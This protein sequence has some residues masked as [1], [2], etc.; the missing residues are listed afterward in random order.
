[1]LNAVKI[2]SGIY[3]SSLIL[4]GCTREQ[5][6][7]NGQ[8]GYLRYLGTAVGDQGAGLLSL[9]NG[10]VGVLFSSV[11]VSGT[12]NVFWSQLN[13]AGLAGGPSVNVSGEIKSLAVSLIEA[14]DGNMVY[15]GIVVDGTSSGL[16]VTKFRTAGDIVWQKVFRNEGQPVPV[17]LSGTEEGDIFVFGHTSGTDNSDAILLK[18]NNSGSLIWTRQIVEGDKT[19]E[20]LAMVYSNGF[21]YL[22]VRSQSFVIEGNSNTL[23]LR[24]SADGGILDRALN[25]YNGTNNAYNYIT[26]MEGE[27]A[28]LLAGNEQSVNGTTPCAL[29]V[30]LTDFGVLA[31]YSDSLRLG[32]YCGAISLDDGVFLIGNSP[33][34]NLNGA[35]ISQY[36]QGGDFLVHRTFAGS[37]AASYLTTDNQGKLVVLCTHRTAVSSDISILAITR[38]LLP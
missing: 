21:L 8:H 33:D 32:A 7:D 15:C 10:Q 35:Y 27:A 6:D 14:S 16:V 12:P 1:M 13:T 26:M 23:L 28:L 2:I 18:Y 5:I 34:E 24:V 22:L 37:L 36:S 29:K 11:P 4:A 20:A 31:R 38:P 3:I 25:L 30:D 19:D 17:A 9:S